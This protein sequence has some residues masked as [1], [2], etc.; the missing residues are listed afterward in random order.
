MTET[1]AFEIQITYPDADS[2]RA[3]ATALVETRLAACGQVSEISS[4]YTWEGDVVEDPEWLLTAKTT[5]ACLR[6]IEVRISADHPYDVPQ[7]TALPIA[8]GS[9]DYL[10]WIHETCIAP[11]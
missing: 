4:V 9:A 10:A 7:I 11:E 6:A 1:D 5:G 3:A 8:W 2:A